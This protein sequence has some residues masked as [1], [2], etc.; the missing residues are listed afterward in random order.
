MWFLVSIKA[1]SIGTFLF[2]LEL[3]RYLCENDVEIVGV[4]CFSDLQTVDLNFAES[5]GVE[6]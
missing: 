5:L 3:E 2:S 1:E 4:N 6:C